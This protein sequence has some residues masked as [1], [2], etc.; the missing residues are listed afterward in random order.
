MVH[1]KKFLKK[2]ETKTS[3][4]WDDPL[5]KA[6]GEKF[7]QTISLIKSWLFANKREQ[8]ANYI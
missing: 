3:V 2:S 6:D 7:K 8:L 1:Q 4:T 5:K